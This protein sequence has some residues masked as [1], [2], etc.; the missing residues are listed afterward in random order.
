[1]PATWGPARWMAAVLSKRVAIR[2]RPASGRSGGSDYAEAV[3]SVLPLA[4]HQ[5]ITRAAIASGSN[6]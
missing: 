6:G 3:L 2:P 4:V 5:D 1:M